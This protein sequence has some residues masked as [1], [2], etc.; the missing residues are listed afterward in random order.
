ME[1]NDKNL[2]LWS[3]M[4]SVAMIDLKTYTETIQ[5]I[6]KKLEEANFILNRALKSKQSE[7]FTYIVKKYAFTEYAQVQKYLK[8]IEQAINK[9][10]KRLEEF[11][12]ANPEKNAE[13]YAQLHIL[14][15]LFEEKEK[16]VNMQIAKCFDYIKAN[17]EDVALLEE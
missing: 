16:F 10:I 13:F 3:A 12:K 4:F 17:C 11:L 15:P 7:E 1:Y 14:I 6:D 2:D 5:T 8:G 9:H